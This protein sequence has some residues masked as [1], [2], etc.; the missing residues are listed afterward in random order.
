MAIKYYITNTEKDSF[1]FVAKTIKE[2]VSQNSD[3]SIA[4]ISKTNNKLIQLSVYLDHFQVNYSIEKSFN[5]LEN[6][7]FLIL[8]E[9]LK[10]VN[11][12]N[13]NNLSDSS[14]YFKNLLCYDFCEIDNDLIWK[15]S[16]YSNTNKISWLEALDNDEFKSHADFESVI[17]YKQIFTHL[18]LKYDKE[19]TFD[20]L[21]IYI[22]GIA[23]LSINDQKINTNFKNHYFS[24]LKDNDFIF[25]VEGLNKLKESVSSFNNSTKLTLENFIETADK[26]IKTGIKINNTINLTSEKS[27][28]ELISAHKSKGLEYDFVFIL[29]FNDK[30]WLKRGKTANLKLPLNLPF[31]PEKDDIDDFLRLLFVAITRAKRNLYLI[32]SLLDSNG[33]KTEE[34]RFLPD[35]LKSEFVEQESDFDKILLDSNMLQVNK[36]KQTHSYPLIEEKLVNYKLNITDIIT[37][38]DVINNGPKCF[39]EQ[40]LL[41][42]PSLYSNHQI[43]GTLMHRTIEAFY[44]N[45]RNT[46][47][48]P[49]LAS[50][51]TVFEEKLTSCNLSPKEYDDLLIRGRVNLEQYYN[52]KLYKDDFDYKVEFSFANQEVLI[53]SIPLS[54][55][56]DKM[57]INEVTKEIIVFDYK[58]GSGLDNWSSKD[59]FKGLKSWKFENQLNFYKILIENSRDFNRKYKVKSGIIEFIEPKRNGDRYSHLEKDLDDSEI[60]NLTK[61]IEAVWNK[62]INLDFPDT[63]KYEANLDGIKKFSEDLIN[64]N[65]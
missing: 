29:N 2:L 37:Y 53:N 35:N 9:T 26:W 41:K 14:Y 34:L 11:C 57:K 28:V 10:L 46:R 31:L 15:I 25:F 23:D 22:L 13:K 51:I 38:V 20:D 33:N 61:L 45:Y 42:F 63:S 59:D 62:I 16:I 65:I 64:K 30:G 6:K 27:K 12:L 55:Q 52:Q 4:V 24:S 36:E 44:N 39:L 5:Y 49:S 54:G 43:F 1:N 21:I 19:I 60:E 32:N 58:T 50:L 8:L 3:R 48:L 56:I 17:K 40:K 18:S 47:L 7:Y